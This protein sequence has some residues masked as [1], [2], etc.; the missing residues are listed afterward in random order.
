MS[1]GSLEKHP[2]VR[3]LRDPASATSF[4]VK[5]WE[6]LI[7]A[8]R[9]GSLLSRVAWL[10]KDKELIHLFPARVRF[11]LESALRVSESQAIS[12]GFEVAQIQRALAQSGI[13][14]VLL[15]GAAYIQ[16][17]FASAH[18]RLMSDIDIMVP[19]NRLANAEK[20]LC[21]HGWF[22]TK[23]DTYD[24]RYYREWMHEIPPMQHL[25]RG[26]VLDVHHTI[27]PPTALLK[28]DV[29]KLW[30][31]VRAVQ[32]MKGIFVLSPVDMVL[33]SATHL[34]HDGELEHGLRDLVDMD[35]LIGQFSGQ[36]GFFEALIARAGELDLTRPLYYALKYCKAF[37]LTPI[38][39]D[40]YKDVTA[41]SNR[42]G[43]VR[44]VMDVVVVESLGA[45]LEDQPS[46][47]LP[48]SQFAMYV[49]SHYL[50][51]P[52]HQLLPHLIRKQFR[53]E[54]E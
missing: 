28:P 30:E 11:H 13:P 29:D 33:H 6:H 45:V 4:H 38:P 1:I 27:L 47:Q 14:F 54:S 22:P 31:S 34:F 19:K 9:H 12:V 37:L 15:K 17:G 39:P 26:T 23:L 42:S 25:G 16:R 46:I 35:A 10:A 3:Y 43:I 36:D 21:D 7:R 32:S 48:I 2:L 24:Q 52:L 20:A 49:R 53:G 51:M 40:I 44:A 18:G 50:R 8:A 41:Y 5:D